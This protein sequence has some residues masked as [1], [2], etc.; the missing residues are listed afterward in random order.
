MLLKNLFPHFP[1]FDNRAESDLENMILQNDAV[2]VQIDVNAAEDLVGAR[3]VVGIRHRGEVAR[4]GVSAALLHVH[5]AVQHL[6]V[7]WRRR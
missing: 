1:L 4:G 2:L 6:H 5:A 3:T 7:T